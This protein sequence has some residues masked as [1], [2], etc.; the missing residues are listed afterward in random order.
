MGLKIARGLDLPIDA[1][2]QTF[3]MIG[4]RGS[5]K[6]NAAGLPVEELLDHRAQVVILDPVGNWHGLR[7]AGDG[8]GKGYSIPVLGGQHGDVPLEPGAGALVADLVIDK[9]I[10]AVVDVSSFRKGQRKQFVT[11]FA[12]QLFHRKKGAPSPVHIVLEEAQLFAPQHSGAGDARMLGAIEDIVRLGRNYGIG[13]TLISQRPQSVNK[14]VLGQVEALFVLQLNG[15]HERKAIEAWVVDQG[16][17]VGAMVKE[18]PGLAVG[19]AFVWSP[20]WLDILKKF[21]IRKKRTLDANATPTIGQKMVEA[22]RLKPAEVSE[23]AGAMAEVVERAEANDPKALKRKLAAAETRIRALEAGSRQ[24]DPAALEQEWMEGWQSAV[25]EMLGAVQASN[26]ERH[27]LVAGATE[28]IRAIERTL[29]DLGAPISTDLIKA[30][31]AKQ[32]RPAPTS[33][34]RRPAPRPTNGAAIAD[35]SIPKGQVAVLTA[36]AQTANGCT[37]NQLT[38]LTGYKRST[39]DAYIQRLREAGLV[40]LDGGRIIATREGVGALGTFDP[41]PTGAAL[42]AHWLTDGRLPYGERSI[43][44]VVVEA[45]PDGMPRQVIEDATGFKRSTRDAYIQRL[46]ARELVDV[47]GGEIRAAAGLFDSSSSG[48]LP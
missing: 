22:R 33:K 18:L 41:L 17:D 30:P 39:R 27:E 23:L 4:R 13:C 42:R 19:V 26:A 31:P 8:K 37:R 36:C 10:S 14:N 44:K 34:S 25:D 6:T 2:T 46:R 3:G 15:S 5:G 38:V 1:V 45:W 28:Q 11:D 43:L 48:L 12:E 35:S 7:T 47:K 20:Q 16:I 32:L 24:I 21:K 9:G 40:E 29:E